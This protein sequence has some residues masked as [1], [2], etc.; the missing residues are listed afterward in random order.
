MSPESGHKDVG[1]VRASSI[2]EGAERARTVQPGEG[3]AQG[4]LINVYKYL[5]EENE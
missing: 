3:N 4:I 5:V 1:R 2:G